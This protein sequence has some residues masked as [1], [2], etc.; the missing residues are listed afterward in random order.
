MLTDH[1]LNIQHNLNIGLF[2][3]GSLN[4]QS[5]KS[6]VSSSID[7]N[8]IAD[9]IDMNIYQNG[10]DL[11][12]DFSS[13]IDKDAMLRMFDVSGKLVYE[14]QLKKGYQTGSFSLDLLEEKVYVIDI[15]GVKKAHKIVWN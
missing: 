14:R 3:S 11:V 6:M 7:I 8:Q 15:E 12:V 4:P 13:P 10:I 1:L 9:A 2:L 5:L